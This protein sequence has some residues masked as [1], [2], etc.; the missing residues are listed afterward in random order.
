VNSQ[1][2]ASI[3]ERFLDFLGEHTLGANFGKGYF[4]QAIAGGLDDLDFD[5]MSLAAE[6]RRD[7]VGLPEG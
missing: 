6:E 4:L 3:S 7:V 5:D 2:D 1:V